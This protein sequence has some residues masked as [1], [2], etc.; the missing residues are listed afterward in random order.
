MIKGLMEA[1]IGLMLCSV[2]T[3][4]QEFN[5][6]NVKFSVEDDHI[7]IFYD[8]VADADKTYDCDIFLRREEFVGFKLPLKSVTG[9]IG[10]KINAGKGKKIIWKH[11]NEYKIDPEVDDYYFELFIKVHSSGY[12]WYTYVAAVVVGGGV[13]AYF[14]LSGGKDEEKPATELVNPPVRPR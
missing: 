12:P 3:F 2:I 7:V 9:D 13:G 11:T 14:L 10:E 4:A 8:L 6:S 5:P 1:V